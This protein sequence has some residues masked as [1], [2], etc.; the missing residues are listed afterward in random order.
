MSKFCCWC[1]RDGF[2]DV[3]WKPYWMLYTAGGLEQGRE[4][5]WKPGGSARIQKV[6]LDLDPAVRWWA[7]A[8]RQGQFPSSRC[9]EWLALSAAGQLV[10][11]R[12][13]DSVHLPSLGPRQAE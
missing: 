8:A 3:S 5:T 6:F 9:V 2:S 10:Q 7:S 1:L 12:L 4:E 13:G 11:G